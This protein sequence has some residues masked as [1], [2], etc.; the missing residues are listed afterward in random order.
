MTKTEREK[1]KALDRKHKQAER[2]RDKL[3]RMQEADLISNNETTAFKI[4][5]HYDSAENVLKKLRPLH[6]Q[7]EKNLELSLHKKKD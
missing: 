7:N 5:Q 6:Q 1:L 2:K 3:K 4:R